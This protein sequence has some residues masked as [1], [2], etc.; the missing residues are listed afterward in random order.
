[1]L[2][3]S[4]ELI[5][6]TEINT[7]AFMTLSKIAFSSVQRLAALNLNATR[8]ALEGGTAAF[9]AMLQTKDGKKGQKLPGGTRGTASNNALAYLKGVQDIAAET[10]QEVTELVTSY[11]TPHGEDSNPSAGWLKGFE[12]FKSFAQQITDMTAANTKVV[13]DAT[14]RIATVAASQSKKIA[15]PLR[16]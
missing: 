11:F 12:Q 13:G 5:N 8:V 2:S 15:S 3:V 14:A 7:H 1:M 16:A 4:P 9:G 6:S 10:Q